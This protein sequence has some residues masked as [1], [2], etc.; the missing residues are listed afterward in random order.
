M[1]VANP[2]QPPSDV[3]MYTLRPARP[4]MLTEGPTAEEQ[5]LA[6]RHWAYSQELLDQGTII[7]GGRTVDAGPATF[8]TV[9][10]RAD[11]RE[12]AQQIMENDPAV[13][14]GLFRGTLFAY[15][16]MLIGEWAPSAG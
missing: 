15:Q 16:P 12:A 8:A 2:M 6:G 3:F 13:R 9:V 5:A 10:I 7:F 14:H 11:S 1:Y 4:E